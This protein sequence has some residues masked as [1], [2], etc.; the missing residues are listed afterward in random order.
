MAQLDPAPASRWWTVQVQSALLALGVVVLLGTDIVGS[1]FVSSSIQ[2]LAEATSRARDQSEAADEILLTLREAESSQRGYLLTRRA[3]YLDP[4]RH[5]VDQI[6]PQ[7]ARLEALAQGTPWLER[8]AARLQ[9]MVRRRLTELDQT[10][11]LAESQGF[12]TALALVLTDAGRVQMAATR[13]L[14]T[15]ISNRA[16]E[17]RAAHAKALQK[18]QDIL[19][20]VTFPA[21]AAGLLLLG[22][23]GLRLLRTRDALLR[24]RDTVRNQAA[25]L[26]AAIEHIR[27]GVAVFD[28]DGRVTLQNTRFASTL[29]L[30]GENVAP[31]TTLEAIAGQVQTDPP[32]LH[33]PPPGDRP[34]MAEV[35][36]GGRV[37]EVWRSAMPDG[38]QILAVADITRRV[39]AE[40]IARQAQ[41]MEMIGQMTGGIAHDFNNLLQIVSANLELATE[42]VTRSGNDRQV[43]D[44]LE[45]AAAG[46]IRGAQLTRHLLAFARRQP[47]AP[48]AIDPARLMISI[49]DMLRRTLGEAVELKV[50]IGSGLW[51]MRADPSQIESALLNLTLNAR[52]AMVRA[53]GVP[54]G[55]VILEVA[56]A[57]LD[58]D[59]ARAHD[60]VTAGQYIMFAVSD[61]GIGMSRE[62]LA[63]AME[64][65]YTTKP[66]GKGTGLGL[67]MVFGFAKQSGGHFQ[68][69]S[70]PGRGTT[71]RLYIPRT[72]AAI[73]S[74]PS[75]QQS[76]QAA[77][78]ELVLLVEDDASVRR[79][80]AAALRS[81]GYA[82]QEAGN[83]DEALVLLNGGL[84]PAVL[85]TDV[86]MPGT[87]DS[88]Q[89][90]IQAKALVPDLA[91]LFTSGYTQEA[92]VHNGQLGPGLNLLSKPWRT[93]ELGRAV[94]AALDSVRRPRPGAR[95]RRILLVEDEALVRMTTADAL[96]DLGFDV[97][98]ADSG[99]TALGR[100]DPKPDLLITDLGLP[101]MDGMQLATQIRELLP[102]TPVVIVSGRSEPPRLDAVFLAKPYDGRDLRAA[103]E[104]ALRQEV[105]AA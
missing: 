64:P 36:Q 32:F 6:G 53:D 40:T 99:A 66:D 20:R 43:L 50:H 87:L 58:E 55:R 68:L 11:Q 39:Q 74:A 2:Q 98:E 34:V 52:D 51:A 59:Y 13:D 41:K 80:A 102:G 69:Y 71:A 93:E 37:L 92:I 79:V 73:E 96:T 95:R 90:A 78:G 86:V 63:R 24:A 56:N 45:A 28:V 16:E 101:D 33:G 85:F 62:Q 94:H 47:L 103:V 48:E 97:V 72:N 84:R 12:D 4:Y 70:E 21:F 67:P 26:A 89:L 18:R 54:A 22:W 23:A 44:R 105:L 82:V 42:Q 27:D 8:D 91:V 7:L 100:L 61:T 17:E 76:T 25:R 5:D 104:R 65:F 88:R 60:E 9:E 1:G 29:G 3:E 14:V 15:G 35:R 30:P 57:S 31:G 49:E 77:N 75:A 10:I 83:G 46:V 81:L 38:G 19:S